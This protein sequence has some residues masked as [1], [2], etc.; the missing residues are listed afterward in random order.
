MNLKGIVF[1]L[2]NL[3]FIDYVKKL[4]RLVVHESTIKLHVLK[5]W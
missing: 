3:L 4:Q 1:A 2:F 5:I